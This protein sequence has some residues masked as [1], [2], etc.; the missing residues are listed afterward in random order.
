MTNKSDFQERPDGRFRKVST[1]GQVNDPTAKAGPLK[2]TAAEQELKGT[3][4]KGERTLKADELLAERQLTHEE[5]LAEHLKTKKLLGQAQ[6]KNKD[7]LEAVRYRD[8]KISKLGQ[9][10]TGNVGRVV[11]S[12]VTDH[13]HLGEVEGT[14]KVPAQAKTVPKSATKTVVQAKK[15]GT[16]KN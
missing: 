6:A 5:L 15:T 3:E 7:L 1:A 16:L 9:G 2:A 13:S 12:N 14:V 10:V 11:G 8:R 4:L